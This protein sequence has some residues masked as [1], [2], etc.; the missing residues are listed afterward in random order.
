MIKINCL[1][2]FACAYK[3]NKMYSHLIWNNQSWFPF[4]V[5]HPN[6]CRMTYRWLIYWQ[7]ES[8]GLNKRTIEDAFFLS[9][10]TERKLILWIEQ[11]ETK[12]HCVMEIMI[13]FDSLT[14]VTCNIWI[15]VLGPF[16]LF[17]SRVYL[18][19]WKNSN[20]SWYFLLIG[21]RSTIEKSYWRWKKIYFRSTKCSI[22]KREN[23]KN[24]SE[25]F[26]KYKI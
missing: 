24:W 7:V 6:L 18:C 11:R 13:F 4:L 2:L 12:N 19:I 10:I 26:K 21:Q 16:H 17:K 5:Q 25:S 9:N 8:K 20:N 1:P 15:W 23:I 22:Q 14:E 3:P